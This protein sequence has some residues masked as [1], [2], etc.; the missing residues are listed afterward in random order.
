MYFFQQNFSTLAMFK[1]SQKYPVT[2]NLEN[3]SSIKNLVN[4]VGNE[5]VS[6]FILY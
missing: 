1:A 5:N 2:L 4:S 6:V 3:K